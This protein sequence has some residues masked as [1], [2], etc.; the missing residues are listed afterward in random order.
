MRWKKSKQSPDIKDSTKNIIVS[1][2]IWMSIF[3]DFV[4]V[5]LILS[6]NEFDRAIATFMI[7]IIHLLAIGIIIYWFEGNKSKNKFLI[8]LGL[9]LPNENQQTYK[10]I[11]YGFLT[12]IILIMLIIGEEMVRRILFIPQ[13]EFELQEDFLLSLCY[14]IFFVGLIEEILFRG[15]LL[16][17]LTKEMS[18]IKALI[19][20]SSLFGIYHF[21]V[22]YA[23]S[24]VEILLIVLY[25]TFAGFILGFLYLKTESIIPSIILHGLHNVFWRYVISILHS[26]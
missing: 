4:F 10:W 12:A 21:P 22:N 14:N 11:R 24:P 1:I 26:L 15:Y 7:L 16:Q 2:I 3:V 9:T 5:N 6:L 8:A 17:R 18:H 13:T 23:I 20:S 25:S 19:I